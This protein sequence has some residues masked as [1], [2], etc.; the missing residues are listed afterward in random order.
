MNNSN[1]IGK[2]AKRVAIFC[3]LLCSLFVLPLAIHATTLEDVEINF[4]I[5]AEYYVITVANSSGYIHVPLAR[6]RLT[7]HEGRPVASSEIIAQLLGIR[8][9][10]TAQEAVFIRG[11][12]QEHSMPINALFVED[13]ARFA[14]A[15][16]I[17]WNGANQTLSFTIERE[18]TV[19]E[20][21]R[22]NRRPFMNV[23][24]ERLSLAQL[25]T[26]ANRAMPHID[27][28]NRAETPFASLPDRHL[29]AN[30]LANWRAN[31]AEWGITERE[32]AFVHRINEEREH[33]NVEGFIICPYLSQLA[34]FNVQSQLD[35]GNADIASTHIRYGETVSVDFGRIFGIT[36][37]GG[38]F[39]VGT[40]I[41]IEPNATF[42]Q[43]LERNYR[44]R[45][46]TLVSGRLRYIGVGSVNNITYIIVADVSHS[47]NYS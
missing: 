18:L 16:S 28:W 40:F 34:R 14:G 4:T 42:M 46:N 43:N 15:T 3:I 31:Y 22:L 17:V 19:A 29:N 35:I 8:Q 5:G 44:V 26:Q 21:R 11:D 27:T 12:G 32:I 2:S 23:S 33:R 10:A 20:G 6:N 47:Q 24:R 13:V 30:E 1:S 41:N 36:T 7:I 39:S 9:R 37:S 25:L 45:H 38:R